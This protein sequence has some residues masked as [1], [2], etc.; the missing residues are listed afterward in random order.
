MGARAV[1]RPHQRRACRPCRRAT[2]PPGRCP[3][4]QP[5]VRATSSS[6][7]PA[8]SVQAEA[9][10]EELV[11]LRGGEA[12]LVGAQLEQLAVGAQ[13]AERQ[14]RVGARREHELDRRRQVVDEPAR[15]SH[16]PAR[17]RAGGSRRGR[18][19]PRPARRARSR[20]AAARP[21]AAAP[22]H[23]R[24]QRLVRQR[25]A[26]AAQRL[27]HVRPQDDR[28]VVALVERHPRHRPARAPR[29]RATPPAAS[30]CRTPPGRRRGSAAGRGR[31]AAARTA[32]RARPSAPGRPADAAW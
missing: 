4:G 19:R 2:A 3:A 17:S 6:T 20:A 27:D 23:H 1:E 22:P 30:T 31:R 13:R 16:A 26:G 24:R 18:A 29:S 8:S 28:V 10:V 11:R 5:S 7:S 21:R 25:R 9:A 12:Q 14:R 32:A 15:R